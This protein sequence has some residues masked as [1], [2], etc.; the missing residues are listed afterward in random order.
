MLF[1]EHYT[2]L[3]QSKDHRWLQVSTH[4]GVIGWIDRQQH[5]SITAEYFQQVSNADFKITTDVVSTILYKKTPISIVMG[6]IVPIT[7]A[8]LFKMEEQF[9][10]NGEAKSIGQRR[11]FEYIKGIA[12]KYVN[13]PHQP[14]GRSPFGI[15]A[16][17]LAHMIFRI[18]G[19]NI[20]RTLSGLQSAGKKV[21]EVSPGDLAFFTGKD[22]KINHAGFAIDENK[23]IHCSGRVRVDH[24]TADGIIAAETKLF[25]HEL[26]A[27][28]RVLA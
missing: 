16:A 2:V 21:K 4:D 15:D 18:G 24:L 27:V 5:H 19:Y 22:G 12:M 17:G 28:R 20:P 8:E 11:D 25:T 14:G 9:A 7:G 26:G 10:F 6:S 23:I 1:G 13:A 3:N